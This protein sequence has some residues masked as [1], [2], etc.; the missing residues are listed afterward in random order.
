MVVA[1]DFVLHL[2][3]S[4]VNGDE[5]RVSDGMCRFL[6]S[7]YAVKILLILCLSLKHGTF[8]SQV[9]Q[10]ARSLV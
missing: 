7:L 5:N 3:Q 6:L 2:E 8:S 1:L 4:T 10:P 9:A